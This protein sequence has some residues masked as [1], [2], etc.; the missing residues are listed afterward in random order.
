MFW[1]G[2]LSL[3]NKRENGVVFFV[4]DDVVDGVV[5][6]VEEVEVLVFFED[7][8]KTRVTPRPVCGMFNVGWRISK[9]IAVEMNWLRGL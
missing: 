9:L 3:R 7:G 4:S 1:Y 6:L 5:D 8:G 2:F